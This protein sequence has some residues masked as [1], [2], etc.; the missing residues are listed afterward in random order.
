MEVDKITIVGLDK[1]IQDALSKGGVE[2]SAATDKDYSGKLADADMI[3]ENLAGDTEARRK[4]FRDCDV[5]APPEAI[6]ATTAEWGI[7]EIAAATRRPGKFVGL[8]FS[9]M[10]RGES[11]LIQ[12]TNG[13][14]TSADTVQACKT[15]VNKIG[16]ISVQLKE[17]SGLI[18]NRVLASTIN[19]AAIMYDTGLATKEVIDRAMKLCASW[20]AGPFELA[21]TIGIDKIVSTLEILS[22]QVG[23]Q[24]IPNMLLRKMVA[25][26]H[27]GKKTGKGFYTY[28][29]STL[30]VE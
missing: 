11:Y 1:R 23:P 29:Q 19:Q 27:L 20:P 6:F 14:E 3:L 17:T 30:P 9:P 22:Q 16:A 8:N 2:I 26:G 10:A 28:P 25:A 12:I 7:T 5:K 4:F 21:D 24:Y 13:L 18:L 15:F